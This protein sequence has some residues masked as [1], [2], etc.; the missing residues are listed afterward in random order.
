MEVA[1][2]QESVKY[3]VSFQRLVGCCSDLPL[4]P[5]CE[6]EGF[7]WAEHQL[8]KYLTAVKMVLV[9]LMMSMNG[10]SV[11]AVMCHYVKACLVCLKLVVM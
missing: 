2:T 9:Q 10:E 4:S 11:G 6:I 3:F 5:S 8:W 7:W 1:N